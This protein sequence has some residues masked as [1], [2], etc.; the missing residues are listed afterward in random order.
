ME[1]YSNK[2]LKKLGFK[3]I[4]TNVQINKSVKFYN[5][6]GLIGSNCRIDNFS[7]LIGNIFIG[8]NVHISA[9]NLISATLKNKIIIGNLSGL[10]P[11]C[12]L[13]TSGENYF[14]ETSNP[15]M[16][17]KYRKNTNTGNILIGKK[18]VIGTGSIIIPGKKNR[19]IKIGD[20][21]SIGSKSFVNSSIKNNCMVINPDNYNNKI[22][23]KKWI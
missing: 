11:K 18:T 20:N 12:Y 9:Y 15:T 19:N 3:K 22:I 8:S 5:F 13:S 6:K 21:V 1:N 10:A 7:I 17:K 16:K 2:E 4:G 14:L 23:K